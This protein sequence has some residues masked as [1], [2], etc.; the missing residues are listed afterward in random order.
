MGAILEKRGIMA[1][2]EAEFKLFKGEN[3]YLRSS[4]IPES[5]LLRHWSAYL[6]KKGYFDHTLS[7]VVKQE[8]AKVAALMIRSLFY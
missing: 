4:K 8:R 7:L 2:I 5:V 6:Q 1:K 3:N